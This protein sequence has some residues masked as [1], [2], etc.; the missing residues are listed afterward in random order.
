MI[1]KLEATQED[2]YKV[3]SWEL[4]AKQ[5]QAAL[6]VASKREWP[7][8]D[9]VVSAVNRYKA[10]ALAA[11]VELYFLRLSPDA[12]NITSHRASQSSKRG[13]FR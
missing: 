11:Q 4:V 8:G 5:K 6:E 7:D 3:C 12:V 13:A 9:L 10:T 1:M 2:M